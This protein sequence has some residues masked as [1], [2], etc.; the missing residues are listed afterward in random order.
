M[1]IRT[2]SVLAL[3][4]AL[5]CLL[6]IVGGAS[7]QTQS[8][9][10]AVESSHIF[11]TSSCQIYGG[12]INNTNAASRWVFLFDSATVPPAGGA[13]VT[14]C[15][16]AA[17]NL[18]PCWLKAYQI[19]A[20]STL[21]ISDFLMFQSNSRIPFSQGFVAVCSSTGPFTNTAAADCTFSFEVLVR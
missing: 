1:L 21:G 9:Q 13:A 2:L 14:G 11:C 19:G 12:S 4:G 8:T 6:A 17:A 10:S 20:N 5:I 3:A 18:R 16:T 15:L 7:A